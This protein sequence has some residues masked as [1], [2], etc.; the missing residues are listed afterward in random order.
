M[1]DKRAAK[2]LIEA[3]SDNTDVLFL[4]VES[5]KMLEDLLKLGFSDGMELQTVDVSSR[6]CHDDLLS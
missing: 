1:T 4:R 3:S 2:G 5:T 6:P